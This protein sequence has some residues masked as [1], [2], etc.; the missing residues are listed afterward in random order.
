MA[1]ALVASI[2]G[3]SLKNLKYYVGHEGGCLQGDV[4]L[5]G[6]KL[7]FWSQDSWGGP[8]MFEFD[9][10]PIVERAKEYYAAH[11]EVDELKLYDTEL[12]D[13]DFNNLPRRSVDKMIEIASC[14]VN[15]V[16]KLTELLKYYKKGVKQGYPVLGRLYFIH[17][18]WPIPRDEE[19]V[20]NA[21]SREAIDK[22]FK[23]KTDKY[24]YAVVEYYEKPEDF[25][26]IV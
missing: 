18:R 17:G 24:P 6:K 23:D 19:L 3:V 5:D 22:E 11:P 2:N 10:T 9:E 13:V 1:R 15:E 12:K 8:D 16:A 26:K 14:L 20:C 7:G 25:I 4:Y 21:M